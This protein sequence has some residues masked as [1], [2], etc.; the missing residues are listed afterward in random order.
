M[1]IADL[2]LIQKGEIYLK[3][4]QLFLDLLFD[5]WLQEIGNIFK[6]VKVVEP[7]GWPKLFRYNERYNYIGNP[8]NLISIVCK[9]IYVEYMLDNDLVK[10]H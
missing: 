9:A 1:F 8:E 3:K 4:V 7:A 5:L 10:K 2:N 6:P